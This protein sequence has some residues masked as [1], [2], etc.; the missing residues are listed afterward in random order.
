MSKN[1][2]DTWYLPEELE[3][4]PFVA[5]LAEA[6]GVAVEQAGQHRRIFYD[7]FDWRL[8][9]KKWLLECTEEGWR[10]CEYGS[11][12]TRAALA[13]ISCQG[14]R[15]AWDFPDSSLQRLLHT[16]LDVRCLLPLVTL[17]ERRT[18]VRILNRDEKTV[19]F[20]YLEE[21]H[22]QEGER[23]LRTVRLQGV[24]GYVKKYRAVRRFLEQ[25]GINESASPH[26]EFEEGLKAVG[27]TPG[28]YSSK[29]TIRL[30]PAMTAGQAARTIFL[31]L[32]GVMERNLPGIFDDLDSEFLHDFRVAIRRTRTGLAQFKK[33]LPA[34][35]TALFKNEFAWLGRVTGPTRDLDV[36][37]LYR[38]DY[39]ARL[40][41]VLQPGL[42]EFF[43]DLA[44]RRQEE[45]KRL[46]RALQAPRYRE[47][48]SSWREYLQSDREE[49]P[50]AAGMPVTDF[51]RQIIY[52][53]YRRVMKDGRAITDRSPDESLHRLRIQCKKLRYALEF[54]TS[55]F[56]EEDMTRVIKQLKKLQNNLGDFNDL[57]V[58]QDM[59]RRHL[60]ELRTGSRKNLQLAA[61]LGGLLTNLYHEQERVRKRFATTFQRFGDSDNT[62]L[63][64][65]L[66]A[67]SR[68]RGRQK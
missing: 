62:A 16:A 46:V 32:L 2:P 64:K 41:E 25:Y 23:V 60:A 47:I 3:I 24:R 29:F 37:L 50:A 45:F 58:Q 4:E 28:D 55:L 30:D 26:F 38:D 56:P 36:Y 67:D 40:P 53:R 19:A 61:A 59:L 39:L 43:Q 42:D 18:R 34:E 13:D 27:R 6:F 15:F 8:Y 48:V 31:Q 33:V 49:E 65:R 14:P 68:A 17:D 20:L 57:S 66:F 51:A 5:D 9:R 12:R 11:G 52:R 7:S 10:L 35:T 21:L 63:F 44:R 1:I 54:F 22:V